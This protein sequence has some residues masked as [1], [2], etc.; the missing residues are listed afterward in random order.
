MG[1]AFGYNPVILVI[2]SWC[3]F[4]TA[5]YMGAHPGQYPRPMASLAAFFGTLGFL[6]S[7]RM[8]NAGNPIELVF[9]LLNLAVV[10]Y[11]LGAVVFTIAVKRTYPV[12]G[13]D[14][15]TVS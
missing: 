2:G 10:L 3:W 5:L 15:G 4:V 12:D 6:A 8:L 11:A 1:I 14:S 9:S 7:A 13:G